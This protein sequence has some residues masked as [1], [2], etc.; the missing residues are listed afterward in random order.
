MLRTE[1]YRANAA[2][3]AKL[4]PLREGKP[5]QGTIRSG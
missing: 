5:A 1:A 2:L 4:K 3:L